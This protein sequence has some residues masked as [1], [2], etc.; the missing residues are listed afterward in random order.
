MLGLE[1]SPPPRAP[2]KGPGPR[3]WRTQGRR[4][5]KPTLSTRRPG[6][7]GR[8]AR[9]RSDLIQWT[10]YTLENTRRE[11][12]RGESHREAGRKQDFHSLSGFLR[13]L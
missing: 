9:L 11:A 8:S 5:F 12:G 10:V 3:T 2:G 6:D 7:V 1:L 13:R 4:K